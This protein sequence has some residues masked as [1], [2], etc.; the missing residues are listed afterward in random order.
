MGAT[1]ASFARDR[2]S[3]T[4]LRWLLSSCSAPR[5]NS[6]PRPRSVPK[7]LPSAAKLSRSNSRSRAQPRAATQ[8]PDTIV[9]CST[10][11]APYGAPF[12]SSEMH[13]ESETMGAVS[14]AINSRP[15][16]STTGKHIPALDGIR[17]LAI[18]AVLYCHLFWSNPDP[19]GSVL[20]HFLARSREAGWIGVDL[21][22]VLSGFLITGIL[23]DTLSARHFFRNF[24]ARRLLR[25]FPLY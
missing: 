22:F 12:A 25:I 13:R 17:G 14:V 15:D 10:K 2:A 19:A 3:V 8:S 23:Y 4:P 1:P 24:Y 16:E 6:Q 21:F 18:L 7:P 9:H 11:G 20:V 5:R